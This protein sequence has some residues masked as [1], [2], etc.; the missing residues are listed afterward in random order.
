MDRTCGD[1]TFFGCLSG[2]LFGCPSGASTAQPCF[3]FSG[4]VQPTCRC[5]GDSRLP[6]RNGLLCYYRGIP[7][8][9]SPNSEE[10]RCQAVRGLGVL[11]DLLQRSSPA[12]A[13]LLLCFVCVANVCIC[14]VCGL[15][16]FCRT[17]ALAQAKEFSILC[18]P[19]N[20]TL[21]FAAAPLRHAA[22][23]AWH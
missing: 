11:C 18:C 3:P 6:I 17:A 20:K 8:F 22:C 15:F 10:L 19:A 7:Y 1:K 2:A 4:L 14:Q 13:C 21:V 9:S 12:T 5:C 23:P 16:G